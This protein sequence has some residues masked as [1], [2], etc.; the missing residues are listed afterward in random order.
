M[1][2]ERVRGIAA[3]AAPRP[4]QEPAKESRMRKLLIAVAASLFALGACKTFD[5]FTGEEKYSSTTKGAAI[6]A[7]AGAVIGAISG[8]D[9]QDRRKRGLIGAGGGWAARGRESGA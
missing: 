1:A 7:G 5:P 4:K 3:W 8:S 2:G 9:A 6:G